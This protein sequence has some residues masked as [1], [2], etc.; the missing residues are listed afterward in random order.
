MSPYSFGHIK[1]LIEILPAGI[2]CL[3]IQNDKR[4]KIIKKKKEIKVDEIVREHL[5]IYFF[6]A[7]QFNIV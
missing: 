4:K 5:N 3:I 1:M 2:N 7:T 6:C